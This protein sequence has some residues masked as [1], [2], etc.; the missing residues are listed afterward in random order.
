MQACAQS[1]CR[2]QRQSAGVDCDV[3]AHSSPTTYMLSVQT[4]AILC[5]VAQ[6]VSHPCPI[7][8]LSVLQVFVAG[9]TG[10][11]GARVLR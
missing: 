1:T 3:V 2:T 7:V 10:R 9:A 6:Q 11:L 8:S 4:R 5:G